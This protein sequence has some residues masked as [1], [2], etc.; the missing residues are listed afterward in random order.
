MMYVNQF[1]KGGKRGI[2]GDRAEK[3]FE[4]IYKERFGVAPIR[5]TKEENRK[6][7]IDYHMS[8]KARH[9]TVD[10]KSWKYEKDNVWVEFVSYGR[11]GWIY[12]GADYI[13]FETPDMENFIMVKREELEEYVRKKCSIIFVD[14]KEKAVYNLYVRVKENNGVMW[15]DCVTLIPRNDLYGLSHWMLKD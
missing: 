4:R 7:H 5:A 15:F 1:D 13:G 2:D 14:N 3:N 11:L 6:L 10:V 12:G 9:A 8:V